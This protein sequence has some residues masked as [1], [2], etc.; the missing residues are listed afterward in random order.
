MAKGCVRGVLRNGVAVVC[1]TTTLRLNP[2]T[3][4]QKGV[5]R[6]APVFQEAGLAQ[7]QRTSALLRVCRAASCDHEAVNRFRHSNSAALCSDPCSHSAPHVA[8][9]VNYSESIAMAGVDG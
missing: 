7:E 9:F 8:L 6:L 5:R 4:I 3:A 2:G 1:Q